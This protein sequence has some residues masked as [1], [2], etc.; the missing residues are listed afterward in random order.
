MFQ[1]CA[2]QVLLLLIG[3]FVEGS[4]TFVECRLPGAVADAAPEQF[5]L[6][7]SNAE[8][9]PRFLDVDGLLSLAERAAKLSKQIICIFAQAQLAAMLHE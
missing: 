3:H 5:N 6:R 9:A 2:Q 7:L 4:G 1:A 8:H